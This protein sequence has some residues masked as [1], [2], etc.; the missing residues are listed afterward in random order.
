MGLNQHQILQLRNAINCYEFPAV[1][2]DFAQN[3]K[4]QA[5]EMRTVEEY[6][7]H[8][9][10]SE[11]ITQTKRGLANVL[12][13]GYAQIGYRNN[14]V[15]EFM[16]NVTDDQV[17]NFQQLVADNIVPTLIEIKNIRMPQFSGISFVSKIFMFLNPTDYCVLDQQIAK[18]R[19][20]GSKKSLNRL[21][22]GPNDTQIRITRH[23]QAVYENWCN[24]C[25]WISQEYFR[26]LFRVVDVER[27]FFNLIQ[28]VHI[29]DAQTIYNAA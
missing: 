25:R 1:Y 3:I 6:I 10:R 4:I 9:L 14:R 18:L 17:H 2:F 15:R 29:A 12:Y 20:N 24:E 27:G 23:N 19:T 28:Q 7:A 8:L 13:W 16:D 22:F 21:V 5:A 26:G 11:E